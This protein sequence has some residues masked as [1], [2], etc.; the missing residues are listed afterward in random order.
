MMINTNKKPNPRYL[1]DKLSE[2]K[3]IPV[4]SFGRIILQ[5]G[6]KIARQYYQEIISSTPNLEVALILYLYDIEEYVKDIIDERI[7]IRAVEG[8][9]G[10]K[11]DAIM[12]NFSQNV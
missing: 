9:Q 12:C 3:V 8:L 5:N 2:F 10:D 6:D 4:Y 11:L 1:L 7:A